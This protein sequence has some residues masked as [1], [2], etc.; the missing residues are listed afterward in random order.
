M[1]FVNGVEDFFELYGVC[2]CLLKDLL[3]DVIYG[4]VFY[5][6]C[7]ILLV[8]FL[9]VFGVILLGFIYIYIVE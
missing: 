9:W 2:G 7:V 1:W 8:D 5:F 6:L 4:I 3:K